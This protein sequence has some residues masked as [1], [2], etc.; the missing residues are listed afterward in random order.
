MD[1]RV[2]VL[3]SL[4]MDLVVH[5]PEF[6]RPGETV[7]GATFQVHPGGKGANQAVA[8]ARLGARTALIGAVGA[9]EWGNELRSK[10]AG[11]GV[12]FEH[13][14]RLPAEATGVGVITI[15]PD[16]EN[17]IVVASGANMA[18]TPDH[19]D[20]AREEIV[21]ASALLLQNEVPAAVN[22]RA[23]EIARAA[24]VRVIWNAAPAVDVDPELLALVDVLVVNRAE[25]RALAGLADDEDV[26]PS[27]IA[28][29]LYS[30]GAGLVAITLGAEGALLFDG[31]TVTKEPAP[32]VEVVDTVAAGDAFVAALVVAHKGCELRLCDALKVAVAAGSLAT[33]IDGAIPSLP[34]REDV[35]GL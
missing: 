11:E 1:V 33:T 8:A 16:G 34:R 20:A 31:E 22:L 30:R 21:G 27:G 26:S 15:T 9:D 35:P 32:E 25:A 23:A 6:P 29:R 2:C 7:L 14:I 5:T 10:L 18:L 3:G 17:A 12:D 13:V 24:D 4:N 19:V 28:R